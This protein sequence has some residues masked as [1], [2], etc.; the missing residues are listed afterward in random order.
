MIALRDRQFCTGQPDSAG[1]DLVALAVTG[2]QA[3]ADSA[4]RCDRLGVEHSRAQDRGPDEAV[5]VVPDADGTVLRF[6]WERE[7][8]ETLRFLGLSFEVGGPPALYDTPRLP[9]P[10]SS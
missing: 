6:F 1:F 3:L 4:A 2:P 5:V 7:T 8:D 9:V 10:F